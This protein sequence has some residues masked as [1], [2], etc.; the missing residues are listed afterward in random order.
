V[1]VIENEH[2]GSWWWWRTATAIENKLTCSFSRVVEGG[3]PQ[4]QSLP[5]KSS[6]LA[7]FSRRWRVVEMENNHHPRKRASVLVFE[8]GGGGSSSR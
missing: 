2:G 1:T 4:E 6:V 3:G 5:L 7:R 8:G